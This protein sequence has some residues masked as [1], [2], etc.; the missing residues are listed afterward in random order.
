[1][2]RFA[3]LSLAVV[4]FASIGADAAAAPG[5]SPADGRYRGEYTSGAHGPGE[6]RLRVEDLR[7]GLHGVRLVEWNGKL[8]CQDGSTKSVEVPMTAG[9]AGRTFS[10]FTSSTV[11]PGGYRFTGRFTARDALTAKVRVTSGA[12][13]DRCDTG[14]ITFEA[15]RVGP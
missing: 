2:H 9:R 4:A 7:P 1:M 3:T 6:P 10:G 11:T 15:H 12:G 8:R 5:F 13:A 14:P